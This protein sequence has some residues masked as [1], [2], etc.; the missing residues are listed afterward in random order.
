MNKLVFVLGMC[1]LLFSPLHAQDASDWLA[2][3][4]A[5][6]ENGVRA[7]VFAPRTPDLDWLLFDPARGSE[8]QVKGRPV[9]GAPGWFSFEAS[10]LL[11]NTTYFYH[12]QNQEENQG[13]PGQFQTLS[14]GPTSFSFLSSSCG[15]FPNNPAHVHMAK[16]DALFYLNVGDLHYANPSSE[17]A[18]PHRKAYIQ[19]VLQGEAEQQLFS[20]MPLIYVWDDHDFC[21][22]N[23]LGESPCGAAARLAYQQAVPSHPPYREGAGIA[24]EF[25]HGRVAFLI[26]DLRSERSKDNIMHPE[27]MQ[28]LEQRLQAHAKEGLF[29][30]L[31]SSVS[32]YGN[33]DDNWGGFP[34]ERNTLHSIL[35]KLGH[36]RLMFICGDAHMLAMDNGSS[37]VDFELSQQA[38][39]VLQAGALLSFGS[40]KGGSYSEGV[41]IPPLGS[42][43]YAK[44][45]VVDDGN[46]ALLFQI[47]GYRLQGP[48]AEPETLM[49]YTFCKAMPKANT[50][51]ETKVQLSPHSLY[52]S[53]STEFRGGLALVRN[54][55]GRLIEAQVIPDKGRFS[56]HFEAS[57]E[58]R[59]I[60]LKSNQAHSIR[61]IP[62]P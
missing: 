29:T 38:I 44:I 50:E 34:E 51:E 4:G 37:G 35:Q 36:D 16:Q 13:K 6:T 61:Q 2:W 9:E 47:Q 62:N 12:F 43:Q 27:Q 1:I 30:V 7:K 5:P 23:S 40:N 59:F 48:R 33:E 3:V 18:E 42:G 24:R 28:W 21:G 56:M 8:H 55:W 41:H 49:T 15:F 53:D 57:Q 60:E 45:E 58:Q 17:R 22:N 19:R 10:G 14:Q 46:D 39:P 54:R 11:P 26:M 31:V 32:W 25:R 52:L 20:K